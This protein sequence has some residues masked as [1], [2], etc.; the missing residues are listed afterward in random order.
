MLRLF[1]LESTIAKSYINL[2]RVRQSQLQL[3]SQTRMMSDHLQKDLDTSAERNIRKWQEE[4]EKKKQ[5][6]KDKK[7][8]RRSSSK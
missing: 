5:R 4:E 2:A 7:S 3:H 1:T 8:S 6:Q